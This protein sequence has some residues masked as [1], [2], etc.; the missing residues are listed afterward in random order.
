MLD[1][2]EEDDEVALRKFQVLV[3]AINNLNI[4]LLAG[5]SFFGSGD[6][7]KI[8]GQRKR[9]EQPYSHIGEFDFSPI[10]KSEQLKHCSYLG[11]VLQ[12]AEY[13]G[14]DCFSWWGFGDIILMY[15]YVTSSWY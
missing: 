15:V 7:E 4:R 9:A 6:V 13:W 2:E 3:I 11:K 1:D 5:Y 8:L 12:M 10:S 14:F